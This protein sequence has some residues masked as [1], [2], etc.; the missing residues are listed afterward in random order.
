[1]NRHFKDSQYYVRR[2][3]A[4]AK[5]GVLEEVAP[6]RERI[7][8]F[9]SN[10]SDEE[11]VSRLGQARRGVRAGIRRGQETGKRIVGRGQQRVRQFRGGAAE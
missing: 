3:A 7:A 5:R 2:A 11:D 9:R 6:V 4:M 1:M 8:Q 10:E